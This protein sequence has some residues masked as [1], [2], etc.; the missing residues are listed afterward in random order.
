MP[1]TGFDF[2]RL[3]FERVDK[4]YNSYKTKPQRIN[5]YKQA[6]YYTVENI[7]NQLRF[8]GQYDE[9]R[10]LIATNFP[11]VPVNDEVSIPNQLSDYAHYL[12]ARAEYEDDAPSAVGFYFM[13]GGTV[14]MVFSHLTNLRTGSYVEISNQ[15]EINEA[16]G[17]F[18]L[19]RIGR[20]AFELY[21][22]RGLKDKVT[23]NVF[24]G[25]K[26]DVKTIIV[27]SCTMQFS[28]Q[29][30][31]ELIKP[32]KRN[33]KVQ[34]AD[35]ALKIEPDGCKKILLDYVKIP[36]VLI[37]PD[38]NTFD[39]ETVYSTKLIYEF[40]E[41]AAEIFTVQTRDVQSFQT[42]INEQRANP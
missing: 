14:T 29:R 4:A 25:S 22:D 13:A 16:N 34:V 42:A 17:R 23:T 12:F 28:D 20:M 19:K 9:I 15:Q 6:I 36:P 21:L 3:F 24:S 7:Y 35:N 5:I 10:S 8:G 11:I 39:L 18:Y 37:D 26:A 32:S 2:D 40:L 27:S 33:P 30:I 38:D 1:I 41:K 31:G